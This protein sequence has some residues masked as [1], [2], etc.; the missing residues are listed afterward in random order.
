MSAYLSADIELCH[1]RGHH[2]IT[3]GS[4]KTPMKLNLIC[5]TCTN[6]NPGKTVYVAYG[7]DIGSFGQWRRRKINQQESDND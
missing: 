3:A 1:R 7:T 2:F 5:V 6:A 4:D